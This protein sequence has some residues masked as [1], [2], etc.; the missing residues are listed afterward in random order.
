[1]KQ[2]LN[3]LLLAVI[4]SCCH[5]DSFTDFKIQS[6]AH[7][8]KT[9]DGFILNHTKGRFVELKL[10]A[11]VESG[12]YYCFSFFC[13]GVDNL[14]MTK[15]VR[16]KIGDNWS[17]LNY[18][19][20]KTTGEFRLCFYSGQAK[21]VT[22]GFYCN[23]KCDAG[24][25]EFSNFKLT[26]LPDDYSQKNLFTSGDF[27]QDG[28][29]PMEWEQS[30]SNVDLEIVKDAGFICGEK[31]LRITQKTANPPFDVRSTIFPIRGDKKYEISFWG[32]ADKPLQVMVLAD[33]MPP[34]GGTQNKR[35]GIRKMF[36]LDS[37]WKQF[38]YEISYPW[39]KQKEQAPEDTTMRISLTNPENRPGTV[40]IDDVTVK[41][42]E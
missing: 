13:R 21:S 5:A 12:R 25:M 32:K 2:L 33:I 17:Y 34:H 38:R 10:E 42:V 16:L 24:V 30:K 15:G 39:K 14:Q 26:T 31:S 27:E 9:K 36:E 4:G 20:G 40:F 1:M 37:Q 3:V 19:A 35:I 41:M 22:I 18:G 28:G 11:P 7:W 6:G 29:T 23:E 8:S